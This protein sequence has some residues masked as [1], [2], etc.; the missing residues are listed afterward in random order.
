MARKHV[1]SH[2]KRLKGSQARHRKD[3]W[4]VFKKLARHKGCYQ[5]PKGGM[6]LFGA[7]FKGK[8]NKGGWMLEGAGMRKGGMMLYGAGVRKAGYKKKTIKLPAWVSKPVPK[9]GWPN[10]PK[11]F[12]KKAGAFWNRHKKKAKAVHKKAKSFIG[13]IWAKGKATVSTVAGKAAETIKKHASKLADQGMKLLD[14][15]ADQ[16]ID[17]AGKYVDSKADEYASKASAKMSKYD[18]K[19]K[20]GSGFAGDQ[21]RQMQAIQAR[22][23]ARASG[24]L[25]LVNQT[26]KP[27]TVSSLLSLMKSGKKRT[28]Q[29]PAW[30]KRQERLGLK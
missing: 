21:V 14:D 26:R 10:V 11:G 15:H 6:M 22:Q 20:K 16:F 17:L 25:P 24:A 1:A 29:K 5:A 18:V 9:S 7:G 2:V 23:R 19:G 28:Y 3:V 27:R 30:L 4:K 8:A 12:D 13:K